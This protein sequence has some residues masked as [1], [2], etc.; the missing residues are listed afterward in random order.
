MLNSRSPPD[1]NSKQNDSFDEKA[2]YL[3][4]KMI[5]H[6][7][8]FKGERLQKNCRRE[9]DI[10]QA[11]VSEIAA[12]ERWLSPYFCLRPRAGIPQLPE[13]NTMN[14]MT[15]HESQS[16]RKRRGVVWLVLLTA[17]MMTPMT[18]FAASQVQA[19]INNLYQIVTTIIT[20]A[21]AI[22]L[23]WG[24]F[25]F[26]SAYQSRDT[27]QQTDSLKKVVAGLLMCLATTIINL[28]K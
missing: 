2:Q 9:L 3:L 27:A 6:R 18:A 19:K 20:A 15:N 11:Y 16:A 22:V 21:G 13:R 5:H 4:K 7:T 1:M 8:H 17:L 10:L 24:V 26:A 12:P 25:E 14:Q 23:A 28:L